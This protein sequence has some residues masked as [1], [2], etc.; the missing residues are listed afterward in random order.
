[1]HRFARGV[2][3]AKLPYSR[4]LVSPIEWFKKRQEDNQN[5]Q[6]IE[7][8]RKMAQQQRWTLHDFSTELDEAGSGWMNR[9][10]ATQEYENVKELQS[11]V[12]C[13]IEVVGGDKTCVD[14]EAVARLDRLK[15][16]VGSETSESLV[17][18]A[19]QQFS[20]AGLMHRLLRHR[21]EEGKPLP[22]SADSLQTMIQ[23]QGLQYM[24]KAQ[25]DR[26]KK[27]QSKRLVRRGRR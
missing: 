21:Y 7:R 18:H 22:T 24:D 4:T 10:L 19:I 9:V 17:N 1:M 6:Y 3:R 23:T 15:V 13:I 25:R 11:I 14:V 16:A 5:Q 12:K 8:I 27:N 2:N 26:F 20:N